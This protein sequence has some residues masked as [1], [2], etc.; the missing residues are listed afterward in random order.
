MTRNKGTIAASEGKRDS[1]ERNLL[2]TA[3]ALLAVAVT[4]V[5]LG[6]KSDAQSG[7][8]GKTTSN[9]QTDA[10]AQRMME[11]GKQTFRF[12]TFGDEAFWSDALQLHRAIAGAQNG[13]VGPGV[14][15]RTALAVGEPPAP[16]P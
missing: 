3:L 4:L 10:N 11:E 14:S 12:D 6:V 15:P 16:G 5:F 2:K 1:R 8:S 13:G 7:K 9:D